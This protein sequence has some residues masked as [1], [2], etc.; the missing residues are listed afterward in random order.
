MHG[1]D[2]HQFSD[3]LSLNAPRDLVQEEDLHVKMALGV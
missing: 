3:L 1:F 2:I